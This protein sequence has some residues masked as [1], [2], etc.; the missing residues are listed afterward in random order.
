MLLTPKWRHRFLRK[1]LLLVFLFVSLNGLA[2]T[3]TFSFQRASLARVFAQIE[4]R[5]DYRFLYSEEVLAL[6][7][8]VSFTVNNAPLDSILRL[9]FYQQPLGYSMEGKHIIVRKKIIEKPVPLTRELRG[10]VVNTENEPLAG[11]TISIKQSGMAMATDVH[12]EFYFMNL[13]AKAT[14]LVTGGEIVPQ[15]VE[16]SPNS[17]QLIVVQQR[18]SVLDETMVI[19][20]GKTSRR[21]STGTVFSVKSN[22]I[23]KQPISNPLAG[24]VGLVPGLQ[25][26]PLSGSPGSQYTIRIRGQNSLVNG[27]DPLIVVDGIPYPVTTIN[28]FSGAGVFSSPLAILNPDDIESI[29]VLKDADATAIYGS[30][31]ANGVI[32]IITKKPTAGKTRVQARTYGGFGRITRNLELLQTPDYIQMRREA[33]RNDGTTPTTANAPDLLVWDTTRNTD[34]QKEFIGNTMR[35][36]DGKIDVSGGT[37]LTQFLFNTGIHREST[38]LPDDDFGERK[39]SAGVNIHHHTEDNRFDL[40]VATTY[41]RN[42]TYLPQGDFTSQILIAPNAPALYK[43]TGELNWE[44]STWLNPLSTLRK[45]YRSESESSINTISLAARPLP[46]FEAK[47]TVGY[48][49]IRASDRIRTPKSSFD[50]AQNASVSAGFGSNMINTLIIEPQI[51]YKRDLK[52]LRLE[53][54]TG[55]TIQSTSQKGLSQTGT[56]YP[57]DDLL[58][59]LRAAAT[60]TT[61]GETNLS[62]RYTGLFSRIT[63]SLKQRY[64][65]TLNA[66]RDGSSRYGPESRYATFGSVGTSWVFSKENFLSK[67]KLISFGKI[68]FSAGV[69]GN[70]QIGDYNYFDLYTPSLFPYLGI[71][72]YQPNK[73]YNPEYSWE[74]VYKVETGLDLGFWKDRVLI[75]LNYYHNT[76]GNQLVQYPLPPSTGFTGILRNLPAKIRNTGVEIVLSTVN[77]QQKNLKWSTSFNLTIPKNKLLAFDN[78]ANSSYANTYVIGKPLTIAKRYFNLGVDPQTG[79]YIYQDVDR[80]NKISAPNDQQSVVFTGQQYYGGFENVIQYKKLTISLNLQFVRQ[81]NATSYLS[82][83]GRPGTVSNQPRLVMNRWQHAGDITSIQRFSNS[84]SLATTGYSNLRLSDAAYSNASFIR[85]RNLYLSYEALK[86]KVG[87]LQVFLQGQNLFTITK[88]QSFDPETKSLMPPLS[89]LTLGLLYKL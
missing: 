76:T 31:G 5:S 30:R 8:P 38:V 19:A 23:A 67:S 9:C 49:M 15:E 70:D 36:F 3:F 74:K 10:K 4:Q 60:V 21:L 64:L 52:S 83:F 26:T 54:L 56:G 32:L 69:T 14:L 28:S 65:L 50:P 44:N 16:A 84:N 37:A 72:P 6:G 57:S 22:E 78:L 81:K 89:M 86:T 79:I 47:V 27:N 55:G 39:F 48:S 43:P 68:K 18:M 13:P 7:N 25:L 20:Y 11:I 51:N 75:G 73:L 2:Q 42:D 85:L 45:T 24:L 58:N 12:G 82:L 33:Y 35:V 77:I 40:N 46:G 34:W 88:Y 1:V 53:V 71:T 59:S 66:R 29:E 61:N 41:S 87:E 17:Y 63:A 80:D 62:Y